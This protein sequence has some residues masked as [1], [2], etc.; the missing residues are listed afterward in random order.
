MP[1]FTRRRL[2]DALRRL[3]PVCLALSLTACADL[4]APGMRLAYVVDHAISSPRVPFYRYD[5]TRMIE[6]RY[7]QSGTEGATYWWVDPTRGID[8]LLTHEPPPKCTRFGDTAWRTMFNTF[9][10]GRNPTVELRPHYA[11]DDPA[12]LVFARGVPT[13]FWQKIGPAEGDIGTAVRLDTLVSFD[14]GRHFSKHQVLLHPAPGRLPP[15]QDGTQ[16]YADYSDI[17]IRVDKFS[18]LHFLVVRAGIAY[19]G[20]GNVDA[21]RGAARLEPMVMHLGQSIAVFAFDPRVDDP[22]QRARLLHGAE[23]REF[24]LPQF[25]VT[26]HRTDEALLARVRPIGSVVYSEDNRRR[27][28]ESLRA[29]FPDWAAQQHIDIGRERFATAAEHTEEVEAAAKRGDPCAGWVP[30]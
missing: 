12:V 20:I 5:D 17:P 8:V 11:S 19:A 6:V 25:D 16:R 29:Q 1:S 23:L 21:M 24:V 2:R 30:Y 4:I 14:G 7:T 10:A 9:D 28:V 27:Y 13:E 26:T 22:L 3:I 15:E 18:E